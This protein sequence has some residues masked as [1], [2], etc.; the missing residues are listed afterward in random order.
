[1]GI[2]DE[3]LD[4]ASAKLSP[5]RQDALR[6]AC[7]SSAWTAQ[8]LNELLELAKRHH[9]ISNDD[10]HEVAAAPFGADHFPP[11]TSAD[12]QVVLTSLHTLTNVGQIPTAQRLDFHPTGL[13]VIYGGNG[14]GKSGYARVLKQAC[15]ARS[16]GTVYPN[17]FAANF[18]QLVPGATINFT[19]DGHGHEEQWSAARTHV[20]A[21]AL[22]GISVFDSDC[23]THYLQQRESATYQPFALSLLQRI[24][25]DLHQLLRP[26]IQAEI[27]S[28]ATDVAP[29]GVI[30][31]DSAAGL[32]LHPISATTD[33][34]AVRSTAV[35]GDEERE[36]LDRLPKE[37]AEAD[38]S[39]KATVLDNS[40]SRVEELSASI[41]IA[42]AAV[43][44]SKIHVVKQVYSDLREAEEA[45]RNAS[46]LLQ[47]QDSIELLQGSG[48]G[49]WAALFNAARQFSVADAYSGQPFPV[50]ESGSRCV[51]CQQELTDDAK[52]RLARFDRFIKD[53]ASAT[54]QAARGL[55]SKTQNEISTLTASFSVQPNMLESLA[56]R[57]SSIAEK[58]TTLQQDIQERLKWMQAF[59]VS[60]QSDPPPPFS[61]DTPIPSLS[62]IA[63]ALRSEAHS[64]R[65][66]IDAN[67]LAS[68]R[69]RLKDL[70]SRLLLAKHLE[71]IE[72]VVKNLLLSSKLE[73]CLADVA[74]I[75]PITIFAS[76][77]SKRHV[78]EALASSTNEELRKLD[79]H[80]LRTG[81]S[82]AGDAG[83][84]RLGVVLSESKIEAHLVLSEAEQKM[85]SLA[86]FM[87]ELSA[88][89]SASG[90]VLDDPVSSLDHNHRT[91]VARR[92]VEESKARQT[93]V[94]THDA[95]FF[96]ELLA[97]CE[98]AG[99]TA[100][101]MS[102][103][104]KAEGPGFV[105]P[106]LPYDMRR[107]TD[108][109]VHNRTV[110]QQ[111]AASFS[112]PPGDSERIA[113]RNAYSELRAT[114]EIGIEETILNGTVMR[115]RDGISVG[116][117]RG[118]MVV[119]DDEF[120]EVQRLHDKCCRHVLAHS[121]AAGQQRS[122]PQPRELMQDIEAAQALFK[123]VKSRRK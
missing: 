115:F 60:Q 11:E 32:V 78:S 66:S 86:F 51:L 33:L 41:Q 93:I 108:R 28:L 111:L 8:D 118:V 117:L 72:G 98:D 15:R 24:S 120:E 79:V 122:I 83:S 43:S 62:N 56:K 23:A 1:M 77:L 113:M 27:D 18:S 84:V 4:W 82:S 5:W 116:R 54:A 25:S 80:H 101:L 92:I 107:E 10:E 2:Y 97:M 39:A 57:D 59:I 96:G 81:I 102:I 110:Q 94:F 123:K 100:H 87:A 26:K 85:C 13:T 45:E 17:A 49:H 69:K 70:E 55:W 29:F 63:S 75:R 90:I 21:T 35:L 47:S 114:I 36:E 20:P 74:N 46:L 3:V 9:G 71:S 109:F 52:S 103:L 95:V 30:S 105:D 65:E 67:A 50:V 68:K 106:G 31:S 48:Q 119:E 12:R 61:F 99:E 16:R 88:S 38:P 64:L 14:A 6:R 112:N 89:G 121:H 19:V 22:R 42:M 73:S 58:I 76:Q 40:A 44:D 34:S 104:H 7:T 53:S 37:I 91:S